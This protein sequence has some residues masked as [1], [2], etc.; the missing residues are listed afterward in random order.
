MHRLLKLNLKLVTVGLVCA[1]LGAGAGVIATAGA[2]TPT[3]HA[4]PHRRLAPRALIRRVVQGQ[5]VVATRHGFVHVRIDRGQ[6]K[7]VSGSQ[8]TLLVGTRR[9]TYRTVTLTLPARTRVRDN[10]QKATLAQVKPGQRAIVI[11]A[12]KRA[13]VIAHSPKRP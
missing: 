4:A 1:G 5:L 10:H 3:S 2:S 8:L 12:P 13:L 7:S 6:V 11:Q 9:A